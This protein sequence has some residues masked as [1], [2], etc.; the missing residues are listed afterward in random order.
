MA[1]TVT[2]SKEEYL[3]LRCDA[4]ERERFFH[5]DISCN[6]SDYDNAIQGNDGCG[7]V[8]TMEEFE[9]ALRAELGI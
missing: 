9:A 6:W 2:I 8:P 7:D 1:D 3:R 5:W 4:E